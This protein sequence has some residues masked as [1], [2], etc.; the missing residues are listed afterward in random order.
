MDD[1]LQPC[2]IKVL[3]SPDK[4]RGIHACML[5]LECRGLENARTIHIPAMFFQIQSSTLSVHEEMK[6]N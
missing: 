2:I 3:F 1:H 6:H 5:F 4:W